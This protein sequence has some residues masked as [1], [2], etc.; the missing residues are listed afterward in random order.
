[1]VDGVVGQHPGLAAGGVDQEDLGAGV[2][3]VAVGAVVLLV[4]KAGGDADAGGGA[5]GGRGGGRV[6]G[7][8]EGGVGD[9]TAVGGPG[10]VAERLAGAGQLAGVAAVEGEDVEAGLLAADAIR[11]EGDSGA[12]GGPAG[13]AVLAAAPGE[14]AGVGAVGVGEPE[15]AVD[16]FGVAVDAAEGVE[17]AGA[18]GGDLG[19]GG[20]EEVVD[21]GVGG[22]GARHGAAPFGVG[23]RRVWAASIPGGDAGGNR[24]TAGEERSRV[25]VR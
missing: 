5:F 16:L 11:E 2:A 22:E 4:V 14:A 21:D 1:M 8:E 12:V 15:L 20:G 9:G 10:E 19:V 25:G 17:E 18:V 23:G 24:V 13:E 6:L 3:E 7:V